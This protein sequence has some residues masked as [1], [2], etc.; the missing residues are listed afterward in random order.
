LWGSGGRDEAEFADPESFDIDRK[1]KRHH[2]SFGLGIR[3][4]P[5][6]LLARAEIRL[7]VNRW[8]DE[9]QSVELAVPPS[10][11]RYE[12]IFGFHALG[13]LP[14]RLKRVTARAS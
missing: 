6:N 14:V 1:N 9:F 7:S 10:E 3:H 4:C 11:I 12:P 13:Q 5:G 8:L 2:T